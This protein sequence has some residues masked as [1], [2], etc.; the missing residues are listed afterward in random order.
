M[1]ITWWLLSPASVPAP[2]PGASRPPGGGTPALQSPPPAQS[3]PR[4]LLV[5]VSG[6]VLKPGVVKVPEHARVFQALEAAGGA[7]PGAQL[8]TV[9]LAAEVTD[10]LHIHVLAQDEK[11]ARS[12]GQAAAGA[13][14]AAPGG[15]AAVVGLNSSSVEELMSLPRVGKVLAERIVA[16]RQEHGPFTRTED[17]DA[18]DGIG[19]KLLEQ[20]LP[21]VSLG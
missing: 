14:G 9:N 13:A 3:P 7:K 11:P 12:Q 15:G 5:H 4:Q 16:W 2:G 19:P 10:G 17:L 21:L 6:A 8:E 1:P 20:L 18:V